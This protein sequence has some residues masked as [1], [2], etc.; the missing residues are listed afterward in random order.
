MNS[1]AENLWRLSANELVSTYRAEVAT[2]DAVLE[3]TLARIED[4]NPR[5]NAIVTLD[6]RRSPRSIRRQHATL[7]HWQSAWST[8]RR[9]R[10][11][12]GQHLGTWTAH[13]L[14]Q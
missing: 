9:A 2:P 7:E 10:D 3:A 5:L 14:G 8:R 1:E 6:P 11:D 4:V 12:Q 13:H